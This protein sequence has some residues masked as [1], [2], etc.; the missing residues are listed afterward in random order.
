MDK[1][2]GN[3]AVRVLYLYDQLVNGHLIN[4]AYTAAKFGV[5][6]RSIQ[7]D[8]DEVRN[9]LESSDNYPGETCIVVY[10]QK[11]KGYRLEKIQAENLTNGEILAICKILL[12]S[13]AFPKE[14]IKKLLSNIIT[15]NVKTEEQKHMLDLINNEL[16]HYIEPRHKTNCSGLLWE[17]GEAIRTN[18]YVQIE[19]LR[20]KDKSVV[21]RKLRPA[22]IMFSEYYFYLTA[23]IDDESLTQYFEVSNDTFPTIYRIDRIKTLEIL[24]E[25]FHVPYRNRFEEGEFRKRVQ[26]MYGGKLQKVKVRYL[27]PDVDAVLDR[28]PTAQI[29]SE[30]NG[31]HIITA[32][33]FGKGIDMW[34]KSQGNNIELIENKE[35]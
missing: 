7:R 8:L 24:D 29:L 2:N 5:N 30:E 12:D 27:G 22:A 28:L 31:S 26:F 34:L 20:T 10:D 32:E 16:F 21:S 25:Q 23:F 35:V 18:H 3:K 4:K 6:E 19:Y 15:R 1:D 13:R 17:L 9:F 11:Q 14:E 33:V